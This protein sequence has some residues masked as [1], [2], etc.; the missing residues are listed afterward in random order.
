MINQSQK[1]EVD[2]IKYLQTNKLQSVSADRWLVWQ[3]AE[4]SSGRHLQTKSLNH[5]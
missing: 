2:I 1:Y 5:E 3:E 4:V